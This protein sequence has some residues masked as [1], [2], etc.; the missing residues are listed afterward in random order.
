MSAPTTSILLNETVP[1]APSGDQNVQF[2][3]DNL[4]PQQSIT[5]YPK[6]ATTSLRGV[7]KPDGTTITIASDGTISAASAPTAVAIPS[8][9][10]PG[11]FTLA[12][13]LGRTPHAVLIEMTAG[14][15]IWFQTSPARYDG[16][17]LY[18]VASDAGLTGVAQCF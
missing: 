5:A 4:T 8:T 11:N 2:Q 16:T 13:G 9:S 17:N 3:S 6:T 7:V 12:H 18:L 10:A 1:A 15:A 14:G